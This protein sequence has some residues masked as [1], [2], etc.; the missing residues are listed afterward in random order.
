M[1]PAIRILLAFSALG[2]GLIHLA[3]G[4]GAPFPLSVLLVGFGVAELGWAVATLATGRIIWPRITLGGAL[5]PVAVWAVTVALGSG[6]GVTAADTGLP[7]YPMLVA[8]L[9]NVFL[10]V[11]LTVIGRQRANPAKTAGTT[12]TATP[13]KPAGWKFATALVVGGLVF[14]GLTTPALAGTNAGLYAVPHGSHSVPGLESL[15][16]GGHAGH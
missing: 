1:T 7:L 13:A 16:G 3:I 6:L 9:F 15:N 10:A 4:A 8:S 11:A 14:S 2:A 5:I 12:E